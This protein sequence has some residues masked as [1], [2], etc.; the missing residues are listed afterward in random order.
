GPPQGAH[1]PAV[2]A[3]R[4]ADRPQSERGCRNDVREHPRRGLPRS[5][6]QGGP[7][8]TRLAIARPGGGAGLSAERVLPVPFPAPVREPAAA[9]RRAA[10]GAIGR[11]P[12]VERGVSGGRGPFQHA[13]IGRP[14]VLT[15]ILRE[16]GP[17]KP[18]ASQRV[19][20][21]AV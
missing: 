16:S 9:P 4:A 11:P 13:L 15:T 7:P 2:P 5:P 1:V 6:A 21:P 14:A 18:R 20:G 3:A 8:V 10:R 17:T 19:A 12:V